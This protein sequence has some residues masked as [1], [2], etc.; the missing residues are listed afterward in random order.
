M[1]S[2]LLLATV[3][4]AQPP[5]AAPSQ[6]AAADLTK[7]AQQKARDGKHDEALALYRQAIQIAPD[8]PQVHQA[9]GV[10]LDIAGRYAEARKHLTKAIDGA[11]SPQQKAGALRTMAMSYAFERDCKGAIPYAGQAYDVYLS[12]KDYYNAGEAA[13]EVAR[14]CIDAGNLDEAAT[15]Y[16][17][18]HDIGLQEPNISAERKDLWAFRLEH[19]KAR[20]AARRGNK[21]E[22]QQ[23]VAAARA[24]LDR[25]VIGSDQAQYFPY[26]VGYVALYTGDYQTALAELQK[27]NQ[28]DPFFLSLIAE[29]YER[30]GRKDEA[31]EYYR[32]ALSVANGHNPPNAYARPLAKEKLGLE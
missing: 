7:Q 12:Q 19:A 28:R 30:L 31:M 18:G 3:L 2:L 23:H 21:A 22:A 25:G 1:I 24:I 17:K 14:V 16:Q 8:S 11:A 6:D 15:W 27:A 32:K 13:N 29:T 9:Y 4:S 20:I 10:A 26:L 5:A